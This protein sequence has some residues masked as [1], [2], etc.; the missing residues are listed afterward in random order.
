MYIL[1][2]AAIV[3]TTIVLTSL[4]LSSLTAEARNSKGLVIVVTFSNL[5]SDVSLITCSGDVVIALMPEGADPHN[6]Q[7]R[8]KDIELLKKA[9]IV[10]STSHTPFEYRIKD[11]VSRGELR[12]KLIEI[13]KI[14]SIRVL[15]NVETKQPNYHM[16]IYDPNNY[17]LFIRY[18]SKVLISLRPEE[19]YCYEVKRSLIEGRIKELI[20]LFSN[21]LKAT[22]IADLPYIQYATSWLGIDIKE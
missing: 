7:L 5:A 6:Y 3:I 19:R 21:R 22:A 16:L 10:I 9:D 4:L 15:R 8:P 18:V 12:C 13:P 17:L 20:N 11:L 1:K 2:L 14:P